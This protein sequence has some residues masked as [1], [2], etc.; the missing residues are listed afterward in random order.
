MLTIANTIS[1]NLTWSRNYRIRQK[2]S[3]ELDGTTDYL[4]AGDHED[5]TFS[6]GAGTANDMPFSV[7]MWIKADGAQNFTLMAKA[8]NAGD[9]EY[10]IF[11]LSNKLYIDLHTNTASNYNRIATASTITYA[12]A[13]MHFVITYNGD[14]ANNDDGRKRGRRI[15]ING[16]AQAMTPASG[17]S[18]TGMNDETS[19]LVFGHMLDTSSYDL[20]GLMADII[21]WKNYELTQAHV[22]YIYARHA[23]DNY[24]VVPTQ[25]SMVGYSKAAADAVV[26][27]WPCEAVDAGESADES[28][29][30]NNLV[31]VNN[32]ALTSASDSNT[33]TASQLPNG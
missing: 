11:M 30:S 2:N 15:Y 3:L 22:N 24:S 20:D 8:D 27:W 17:G 6:F 26:G 18:Y 29:N 14:I 9:Y 5:F 7:A 16:E 31:L 12:G 13:W 23:A 4:R 10:R 25:A 19:N 1:K 28:T 21:L 33:P 32:A